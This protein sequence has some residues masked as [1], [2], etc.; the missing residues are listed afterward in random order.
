MEVRLDMD[1]GL[2]LE[3][4]WVWVSRQMRDQHRQESDGKK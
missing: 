1:M 3:L 2:D 4:G